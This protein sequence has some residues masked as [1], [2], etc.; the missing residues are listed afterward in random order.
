MPAPV[1]AATAPWWAPPLIAGGAG[2]LTGAVTSA[3]NAFQADKNRG[4]QE[5]LSSTAHQREVQDLRAAGLNPILSARHGG[6][7]S[8]PGATAS[9]GDFSGLSSALQTATLVGQLKLQEAQA[10]DISAAAQLK[11]IEGRI[12]SRTETEQIDSIREA[13][14][15]LRNDSDLSSAQRDQVDQMIDNLRQTLVNL[16][17]EGQHS[18]LDLSR[19]RREADFYKGHG[20]A[21][22]PWLDHILRKINIPNVILNR[23]RR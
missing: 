10:R 16:R 3:F 21:V 13:L 5:R 9:A 20:G 18:A 4:F 2:L 7:S 22:A 11:E 14:Y 6:A 12:S 1:V 23:H 19:S 8:P 15:K 17:F